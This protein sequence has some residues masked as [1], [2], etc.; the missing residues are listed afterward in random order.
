MKHCGFTLV[1]LLACIFSLGSL[2]AAQSSTATLNGTVTDENGAVIT[3]ATVTLT[4]A[5]TGQSRA[6]V[7]NSAGFYTFPQVKP[8]K[9]QLKVERQGRWCARKSCCRSATRS[10]ST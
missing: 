10:R 3:G 8:D 9:Y 2:A 5:A 6:T 7:S 4:N 1:A